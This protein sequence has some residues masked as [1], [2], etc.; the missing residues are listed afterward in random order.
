[1]NAPHDLPSA[2]T[3]ALDQVLELAVLLNE[4]MTQSLARE[5]LTASRVRLVWLLHHEGATTQRALADSLKVTPRNVTSLVDELVDTGYVTREPHPTDRRA[6]LVS[7]TEHG[8]S[9]MAEM[10]RSHQELAELLFGD[11]SGR[12]FGAFVSGLGHLLSRVR[13]EL[14]AAREGER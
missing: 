12:Q 1:M 8:A 9:T 7:L 2:Y 10:N 3:E 4:D 5:G 13:E 6:T 11:M 14:Q